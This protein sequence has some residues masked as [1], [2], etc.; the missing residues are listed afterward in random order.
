L[1]LTIECNFSVPR[2]KKKKKK[3]KISSLIQAKQE[4][5]FSVNIG[6][7]GLQAWS[8]PKALLAWLAFAHCMTLSTSLNLSN[9]YS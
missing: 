4:P 2:A 3:K 5:E 8:F 9:L 1:L 7:N 6:V